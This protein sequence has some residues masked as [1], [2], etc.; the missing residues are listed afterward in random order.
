MTTLHMVFVK[1]VKPGDYLPYL[2]DRVWQI[3]PREPNGNV[4]LHT[5][6]S[7][8]HYFPAYEQFQNVEREDED[9]PDPEPVLRVV[10]GVD[11]SGRL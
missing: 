3:D 11:D 2:G 9:E 6:H 5:E 1:D 4:G 8:V 7:G 10:P